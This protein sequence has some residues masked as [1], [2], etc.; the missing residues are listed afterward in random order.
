MGVL[1]RVFSLVILNGV[2]GEV[3]VKG[4]CQMYSSNVLQ[5]QRSARGEVKLFIV[6]KA[7]AIVTYCR[8]M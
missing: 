7:N 6:I 3:F 8:V 1:A 4:I 5:V 2:K